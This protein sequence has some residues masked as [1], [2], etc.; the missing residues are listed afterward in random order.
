[1]LK[2]SQQDRFSTIPHKNQI[3]RVGTG[4]LPLQ[5]HFGQWAMRF[6]LLLFRLIIAKQSKN[7]FCANLTNSSAD[8][9][10]RVLLGRKRFLRTQRYGPSS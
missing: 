4:A 1:M 9:K 7:G 5:S 3:R 2:Y 8:L 6:R 10:E